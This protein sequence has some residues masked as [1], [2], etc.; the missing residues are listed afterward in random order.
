[1]RQL[2]IE[3]S[4]GPL[5]RM[6]VK[7][8]LSAELGQS[9]LP[10]GLNDFVYQH[11]E[12]NP[13]FA[14]A[15]L[16]HLIAQKFLVKEEA[17]GGP[18]PGS[19]A[20]PFRK[21]KPEYP[22]G[23]AQMIELEIEALDTH[24]QQM[25]EAGSLMPVAFPAWAV[26]AALNK[27]PSEIEETCDSL[28]RRLHFVERAGHD[29]LP[30]GTSSAFY[31]FSHGLYREALYERQVATRRA[32]RHIRIAEKMGESFSGRES[33]VAREMAIHFEAAG[34]WQRAAAALRNA[35]GYALSR[36]ANAE[37]VPTAR[38]CLARLTKLQ[39]AGRP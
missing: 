14:I 17:N 10:D 36:N 32:Q 26:A 6:T 21:W 23:L 33:D 37:A 4:L 15:I 9:A 11:S 7:Q 16:E 12:G 1:M 30:D 20:H 34:D 24:E 8:M 28:A 22:S 18:W 3:I 35:A 27:D 2:C 29:E 13:L 25:L 38:A 31:V 5:P 19:R 39:T